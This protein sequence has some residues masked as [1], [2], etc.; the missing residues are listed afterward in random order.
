MILYIIL[1]RY[2]KDIFECKELVAFFMKWSWNNKT[3]SASAS[4]LLGLCILGLDDANA[5]CSVFRFWFSFFSYILYIVYFILMLANR[6]CSFHRCAVSVNMAWKEMS[7]RD[8]LLLSVILLMHVH[9]WKKLHD[10]ESYAGHCLKVKVFPKFV[11]PP[12]WWNL[13]LLW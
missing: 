5:F 1:E 2:K 4:F 10:A 3:D 6:E 9:S 11:N 7:A 12:Y 13:F 8:T